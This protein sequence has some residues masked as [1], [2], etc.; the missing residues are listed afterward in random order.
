MKRIILALILLSSAHSF[1]RVE[2]AACKRQILNNF[3]NTYGVRGELTYVGADYLISVV[4]T[5]SDGSMLGPEICILTDGD[6]RIK[7]QYYAKGYS[8]Q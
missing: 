6:C 8:C 5:A 2:P 4:Q 1:A 3:Q 7:Q